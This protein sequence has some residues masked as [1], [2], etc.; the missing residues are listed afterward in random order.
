MKI[1]KNYVIISL[2]FLQISF[3]ILL[4]IFLNVSYLKYVY[5]ISSTITILLFLYYIRFYWHPTFIF[6]A[7]LTL[8]QGGLIIA[9][10]FDI[11][12]DLSYVT[13]MGA[14]VY[15]SEKSVRLTFLS[16]LLSYNF[17]ILGTIFS[18]KYKILTNIKVK[19][20]ENKDY[21]KIFLFIF[22][23]SLPLYAFKNF[24]YFN[25]YLRHGYMGFYR[26]TE[27]LENVGFVPRLL[28]YF[29]PVS[30][31]ALLNIAKNKR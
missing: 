1:N 6:L 15:L 12:I 22:F 20:N 5:L 21:K 9:S 28:S 24:S 4:S 16:I 2:F 17:V 25:F 18:K 31:I 8:F 30:F 7:T 3:N 11:T 19:I 23:C 13:L 10:I 27:F 29:F 14:N 26:T